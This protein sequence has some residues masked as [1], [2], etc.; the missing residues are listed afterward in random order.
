MIKGGSGEG[1]VDGEGEG[2]GYAD[3][4]LVEDVEVTCA[5]YIMPFVRRSME[6]AHR[7]ICKKVIEKVEMAKR[8]EALEK[9]IQG[10]RQEVMERSGRGK[11]KERAMESPS[12]ES[13]QERRNEAEDTEEAEALPDKI[14]YG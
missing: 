13:L 1:E 3:W 4:V 7:D 5:W 14:T 9:T 12:E 6:G 11:G 8:Q 2:I 10:K